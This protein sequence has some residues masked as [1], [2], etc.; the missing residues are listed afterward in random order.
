MSTEALLCKQANRIDLVDYL[1]KLGFS[2]LKIRNSDY[3]YLSPLRE[4]KT[5]SFKINRRKNVWFDHGLGKGGSLVDFGILYYRCSVKELLFKLSEQNGNLVSFHPQHIPTADEKKE[6][7]LKSGKIEVISASE[8]K[9]PLLREYLNTRQV[10]QAIANR[11]CQEVDFELYEKKHLAVGFRN[12]QGG[13][14]LRNSYFKGSSSPKASRFIENGNPRVIV[15]EGFFDFLSFQAINGNQN[16]SPPNFLILNSLVFLQKA[17]EQMEKHDQVHLYLDRDPAGLKCT[18][19]LVKSNS[20]YV[21]GST[22]Y[23]TSKDLNEWLIKTRSK[24]QSI[25]HNPEP[26]YKQNKTRGHGRF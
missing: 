14:E 20:K 26:I 1:E 2:P 22:L 4:E 11:F 3:W 23:K 5:P 9:D 7:F 17:K 12:D 19:E 18:E 16:A 10:P 8:I 21:D 24:S 6:D 13:Y 25:K 15:F